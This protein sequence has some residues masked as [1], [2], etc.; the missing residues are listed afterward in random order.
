MSKFQSYAAIC[1]VTTNDDGTVTVEGIASDGSVDLAGE[2]VSPEAM[3]AALPN[4]MAM[5][6]GAL[7]EMHQPLE[8]V[9]GSLG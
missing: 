9:A 4:F 5:G 2:V 7:R 3:R 1:K 8:Y 6:T